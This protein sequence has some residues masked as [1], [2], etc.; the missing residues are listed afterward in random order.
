MFVLGASGGVGRCLLEQ[1]A[2]RG[3]AITAQSRSG[4]GLVPGAALH[5]ATGEPTDAAF[6]RQHLAGHDAV[7][8]CLGIASRAPTTLFSDTT[9]AVLEAMDAESIRRLVAVTG[10]GAGDSKGHGGLVYNR[11]IF[12]LF[13]RNRYLDKDRQEALIE[14]SSLDWTI[15]RPAPFARSSGAG[16]LRVVT[17][18]PPGLQLRRVTRQE[19]ACFILD[20]LEQA[21]FLRQKPFIGHE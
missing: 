13:T 16:A 17:H 8:I 15:V 14:R 20:C 3:H 10:I 7:V 5:I 18:I 6:L 4:N 1:G 11:V 9:A 2:A 21:T 12:P 19:V